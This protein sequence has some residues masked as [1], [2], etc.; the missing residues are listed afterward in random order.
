L[1]ILE[2]L[3]AFSEQISR[4]SEKNISRKRLVRVGSAKVEVNIVSLAHVDLDH[5][6]LE[7]ND[8]ANMGSGILWGDVI[9]Q[10]IGCYR[11]DK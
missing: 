1:K 4:C 9:G 2:P 8:L 3:V 5:S 10:E 6:A 7:G 11:E